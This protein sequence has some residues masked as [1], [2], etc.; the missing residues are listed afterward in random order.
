M[1]SN[2][3]ARPFTPNQQ[4]R[5]R[6]RRPVGRRAAGHAATT[7]RRTRRD[8]DGEPAMASKQ[9]EAV[10]ELYRISVTE[11]AQRPDSTAEDQ[12]DVP[13]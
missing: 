1:T 4:V 9:S 6:Q 8:L 5:V 7:S 12:R 11:A 13:G 2:S 10:S 3:G